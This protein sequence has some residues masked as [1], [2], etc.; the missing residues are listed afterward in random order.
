MKPNHYF[1]SLV[2]TLLLIPCLLGSVGLACA[3]RYCGTSQALSVI[4][5]EAL[6][7]KLLDQLSETY[8][9]TENTTGIP[10]SVYMNVIDSAVAEAVLNETISAGFSYLSGT[11]DTLDLSLELPQ[12][13]ASLEQFFSDYAEENGYEKDAVYQEKLDQAISGA[14][15]LLL[16]AGD[17]F[18]FRT[19]EQ[20]GILKTARRLIP[21][22]RPAALAMTGITA[23]LAAILLLLHRKSPR[24]CAYWLGCCC[25][26][27]GLVLSAP[28]AYLWASDYFSQFVIK[29]PG[30]YAAITG[31]LNSVNEALL[32]RGVILLLA[33]VLLFLIA[34]IKLKKGEA[35]HEKA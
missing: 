26:T 18:R 28:T 10:A 35:I 33:A 16:D 27:G 2:L 11:A 20:T 24:Q 25:F 1:L 30:I 29:S 23:F 4:E 22:L 13:E 34:A 5:Q 9:T 19:L 12:L 21:W 31:Y 6:P 15:T 14:Y 7:Q 3:H 8:R 32:S 17:V